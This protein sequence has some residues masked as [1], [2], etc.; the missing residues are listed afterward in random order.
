MIFSGKIGYRL[1]TVQLLFPA[2]EIT[3]MCAAGGCNVFLQKKLINQSKNLNSVIHEKT[4]II[5][6][7]NAGYSCNGS[8]INNQ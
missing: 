2:V 3:L 6:K 4:I 5:I 1:I 8:D 7:L